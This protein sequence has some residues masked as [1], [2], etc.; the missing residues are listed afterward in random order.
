MDSLNPGVQKRVLGYAEIQGL[1]SIPDVRWGLE[2]GEGV[3][4]DL[5]VCC[6]AQPPLPGPAPAIPGA[7]LSPAEAQ[8]LHVCGVVALCMKPVLPG[9][10]PAEIQTSFPFATRPL[11]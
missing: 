11:A 2:G 3:N 7:Q 6:A 4:L 1:P 5:E 9:L 10:K 8:Q